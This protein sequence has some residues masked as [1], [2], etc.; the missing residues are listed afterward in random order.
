MYCTGG[1][2][3]VEVEH[4]LLEGQGNSREYFKSPCK[5]KNNYRGDSRVHM[6]YYASLQT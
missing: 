5:V 4:D 1:G 3:G 6:N 2:G